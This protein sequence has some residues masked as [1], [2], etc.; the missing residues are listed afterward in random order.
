MR[1]S[2][3]ARRGGRCSGAAG[4]SASPPRSAAARHAARR[5]AVERRRPLLFELRPPALDREGLAAALRQYL[6]QPWGGPALEA[7]LDVRLDGEPPPEA[8]GGPGPA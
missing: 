4:C 1:S 2:S 8:R 6:D 7:V 3:T 5:E